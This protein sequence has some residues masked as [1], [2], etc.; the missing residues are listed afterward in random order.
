MKR[1]RAAHPKTRRP[2]FLPARLRHTRDEPAGSEFSEGQARNFEPANKG[3]VA[4]AHFATIDH[5]GGAGIARQLRQAHIIFLRFELSPQGRVFLH[6]RALA[7]VAID[8]GR[9]HHKGTRKVAGMCRN[10]NGF[11]GEIGVGRLARRSAAEEGSAFPPCF[12]FPLNTDTFPASAAELSRRL[13]DSLRDLFGL[14][15]DSVTLREKSY[16]HLDSLDVC[17]NGALLPERP[18]A[19]PSVSSPSHPA[20]TIDSFA[21]NGSP[22]SVG[23]ADVDFQLIAKSVELHRATDRAGEILLLLHNAADGRVE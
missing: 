22:I 12:M 23:P 1:M 6:G 5:P 3:T 19:I 4:A 10:A 21:V 15:H 20:L 18:P 2:A 16:P 14:T 8:P 11:S 17:L 13:N 9:F 7:F